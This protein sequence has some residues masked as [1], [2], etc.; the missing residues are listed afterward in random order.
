[1]TEAELVQILTRGEDS[2]HQFKREAHNADSIAAELAALANSGGGRLFLGVSDDGQIVGLDA[3]NI[4]RVNQLLSNAASQHVRPP[5]H[6]ITD[7]VQTEHGVVM[8]VTISDGLSKPYI[9]NHGRIWV[10]NGSDK[11]HVTAREEIQRL[12]QRAGLVYA[13][14]IPVTGTSTD[15][16]DEKAFAAY[17]TR[18]YGQSP[19]LAGQPL[20]QLLQNLGLGDGHELNLAGLMLFG[21][22]PQRYRPAFEVKAVAFPGLVLHDSRYL[23]SEDI[24]GT[25]LEQYQ[26]SFAFIKRNLRHIQADRGFNTLG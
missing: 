9:D 23:D 10:K 2:R 6:P 1:M 13:D 7:N 5:I 4:R 16:I 8:V 19:E 3:A 12:F 25:L 21:K 15:D 18:R 20:S 26:R 24:G 17:F 14:V 11:R 22:R